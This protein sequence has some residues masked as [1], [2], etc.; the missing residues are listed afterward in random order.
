[1]DRIDCILGKLTPN[2]LKIESIFQGHIRVS[3]QRKKI[4]VLH[5]FM[6]LPHGSESCKN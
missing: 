1:M 6:R 5:H 4:R 2:E 3:S